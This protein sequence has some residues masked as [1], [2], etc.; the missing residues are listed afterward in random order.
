MIVLKWSIGKLLL[1]FDAQAKLV[2]TKHGN[3]TMILKKSSDNERLF[4]SNA[5]RN[6]VIMLTTCIHRPHLVANLYFGSILEFALWLIAGLCQLKNWRLRGL[7]MSSESLRHVVKNDRDC[8]CWYIF[9]SSQHCSPQYP[10]VF[11][12]SRLWKK[13]CFNPKKFFSVC[14][15]LSRDTLLLCISLFS[16]AIIPKCFQVVEKI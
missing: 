12:E 2:K 3:K 14:N 7:L 6:F 4:Q 16:S 9:H 11:P 1:R 15:S 13:Y 10:Q 8:W 5:G